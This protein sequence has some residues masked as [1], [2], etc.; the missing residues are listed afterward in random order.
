MPAFQPATAR[1]PVPLDRQ[2]PHAPSAPVTHQPLHTP[3][4]T[5]AFENK[6]DCVL[7]PK[8][9]RSKTK[10]TTLEIHRSGTRSS[11][12][13]AHA[14]PTKAF[15]WKHEGLPDDSERPS[16]LYHG[17]TGAQAARA[18]GGAKMERHMG[19]G[20]AARQ[21][22]FFVRSGAG[23]QVSLS[24]HACRAQRS[25]PGWACCRCCPSSPRCCRCG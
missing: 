10:T 19:R 12:A 7:F 1:T 24:R 23:R 20:G 15:A 5:T 4:K 8:R 6:K 16:W 14:A 21:R 3:S 11:T 9:L 13:A 17:R 22:H 18:D 25:A 2:P